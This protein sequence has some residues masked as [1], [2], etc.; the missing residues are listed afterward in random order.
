MMR[1]RKGTAHTQKGRKQYMKLCME[2]QRESG[3]FL[4][5]REMIKT[6]YGINTKSKEVT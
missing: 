6:L 1:R 2:I 5:E 3:E 4:E